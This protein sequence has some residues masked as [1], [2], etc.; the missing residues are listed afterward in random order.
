MPEGN[1]EPQPLP[2]PRGGHAQPPRAGAR[3]RAARQ[4]LRGRRGQ[5][6]RA[7]VD[8]GGLRH[9]LRREDLAADLPGEPPRARIP[10]EGAL[11]IAR[12]AGG[13]LW[14][15]AAE[16]GVSYRSYGEFIKNG[17]TPDDPGTTVGQGPGGALRPATSAA[18]T[19]TIPT[20]K[21]AERF[22]DELAGFEKAG[23]M[24]R[25]IVLRLPNDHTA[26]TTPGKPTAWPHVADN[27]LALGRVVEGREQEPVLEGDGDLRGRGRR[28][29]RLG[30][31]RRPPHGRPG[32]QPVHQAARG[33]FDDVQH[34]VDAP[35]DG[36]DPGPG[37]DEPVRRRRAADVDAAFTPQADLTPYVHRPAGVDLNA[38]NPRN[39]LG[40][41]ALPA[42]RTSRSRTAPTTC[43]STRSSGRRSKGSTRPCPRPSARR[44]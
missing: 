21:R 16:K 18:S 22:L 44:S 9:R 19:W 24:P 4:L 27:D 35:D 37:A 12:P 1:G 34:L 36:A 14:D 2:L 13:Y 31:R 29:E 25:L 23:E 17:K 3:V 40:G 5:R 33:R 38:K 43:S 41:R 8:D 28:P 6:R 10:S 15:R 39:R 11:A 26:G 42:A 20:S 7:R 30:P 32:D